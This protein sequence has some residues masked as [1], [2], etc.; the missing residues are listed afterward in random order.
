MFEQSRDLRDASLELAMIRRF[1]GIERSRDV[2]HT[3]VR[4]RAD[5]IDLTA[6][7][8]RALF[9]RTAKRAELW[10]RWARPGS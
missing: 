7:A 4:E 2:A 8:H 1:R 6:R 9:V 5:V 3:F 10:P